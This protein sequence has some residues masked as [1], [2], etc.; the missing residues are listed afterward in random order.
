MKK[1]YDGPTTSYP[2]I[3]NHTGY[4][5]PLP[6]VSSTNTMLVRM[7]TNPTIQYAGFRAVYEP[8]INLIL[9]SF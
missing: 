6:A 7:I 9:I 8:V 1:A 2:V 5:N 3:L 4:T